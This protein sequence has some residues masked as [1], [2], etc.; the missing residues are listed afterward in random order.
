MIKSFFW[1]N[2]YEPGSITT[3]LTMLLSVVFIAIFG[4]SYIVYF[5]FLQYLLT[6]VQKWIHY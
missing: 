6:A 1:T 3:R 2:P 4:K 5:L